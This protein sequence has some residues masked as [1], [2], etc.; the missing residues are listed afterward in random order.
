VISGIAAI[1]DPA[2]LE[3]HLAAPAPGS[4]MLATEVTCKLKAHT[5]AALSEVALDPLISMFQVVVGAGVTKFRR[6]PFR[7]E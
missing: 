6:I 3:A 4:K 5:K 7:R 1:G 2:I